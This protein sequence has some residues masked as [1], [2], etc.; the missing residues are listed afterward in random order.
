[1]ETKDCFK[2][3]RTFGKD[4][5]PIRKFRNGLELKLEKR[6]TKSASDTNPRPKTI[7]H[8]PGDW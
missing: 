2:N 4:G 6:K 5:G 3:V 8:I 7:D 1:M